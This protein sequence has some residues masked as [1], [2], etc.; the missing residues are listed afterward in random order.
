[1]WNHLSRDL[2]WD[3][4]E[5]NI[6]KE[7]NFCL[8]LNYVVLNFKTTF[9]NYEDVILYSAPFLSVLTIFGIKSIDNCYEFDI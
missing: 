8:E 3:L 5:S 7:I 4:G 1:M 9:S 6:V 2:G